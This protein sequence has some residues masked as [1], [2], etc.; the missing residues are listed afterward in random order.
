M[1]ADIKPIIK[2]GVPKGSLEE[3]TINLFE[4]AGWKIRKHTRNFEKHKQGGLRLESQ[5]KNFGG[6]IQPFAGGVRLRSVLRFCGQR[7]LEYGQGGLYRGRGHYD[8]SGRDGQ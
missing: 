8:N 6:Y 5:A 4:R 2:L 1:S 3:A 7:S